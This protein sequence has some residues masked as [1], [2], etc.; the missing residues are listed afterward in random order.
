MS[1]ILLI[2]DNADNLTSLSAT[3]KDFMHC[4]IR[5]RGTEDCLGGNAGCYYFR[6]SYAWNG[7]LRST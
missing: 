2:D 6:Y 4:P 5:S 1:K 7:W 3:I